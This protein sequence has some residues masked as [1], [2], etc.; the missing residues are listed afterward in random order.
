MLEWI[1]G[2][3]IYAEL[4]LQ[5]GADDRTLMLLEGDTD[6]RSLDGHIDES[7][8]LTIPCHGKENLVV[9]MEL[10]DKFKLAGIV[11][12][13]DRDWVG[14]LATP[15]LPP[16]IFLTDFYDLDASIVLSGDTCSRVIIGFADRRQL[17]QH[18]ESCGVSSPRDVAVAY[19]GPV[20][21]LRLE[22]DRNGL[23][24]ALRDFPMR[25]VTHDSYS[26]IDLQKLVELA[27]LRSE[28]CD[29]DALGI[30]ELMERRLAAEDS[31]AHV[32]S[33][34][35]LLSALSLVMRK[36]WGRGISVEVLGD[37]FRGALSCEDLRRM[38]FYRKVSSAIES[39]EPIWLCDTDHNGRA[40]CA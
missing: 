37:S 29:L 19:A 4:V 36:R 31:L 22:S 17:S 18:L 15:T 28:D 32:C 5:K 30:V 9:A 21:I 27:I 14:Y 12:I 11:A 39:K 7:A 10:V 25:P 2:E 16:G 23:M 1:T 38:S 20:G 26:R 35:D 33:G 24:L 34:H 3:T 40:E 6:C 8:C 13:R